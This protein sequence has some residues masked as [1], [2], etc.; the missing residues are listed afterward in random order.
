MA[1]EAVASGNR[2]RKAVQRHPVLL[3]RAEVRPFPLV[4]SAKKNGEMLPKGQNFGRVGPV[5]IGFDGLI[6]PKN[7]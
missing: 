1:A 6:R 4:V 3:P 5:L 2:E 7:I